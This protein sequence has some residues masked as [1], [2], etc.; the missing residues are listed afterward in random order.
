MSSAMGIKISGLTRPSL[1]ECQR[2]KHL[3]PDQ[4]AAFEVDL[5]FVIR[6][7]FARRDALANSDLQLVAEPQFVFHRGLEP[8]IAV[9]AL[10]LGLVHRDIGALHQRSR[11]SHQRVE[12]V[13]VVVGRDADRNRRVDAG[14]AV[15]ERFEHDIVQA[16][17]QIVDPFARGRIEAGDEGEFVAAE[18]CQ[19]CILGQRVADPV[20]ELHQHRI[21]QRMPVQIVDLFE[22]VE[23][24]HAIGD[25]QAAIVGDLLQPVARL[26]HAA[27]V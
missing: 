23:V 22:I 1:G 2:A 15:V 11:I 4:F 3:E 10:F 6:D 19:Q 12:A 14:I 5:L 21:A 8:E 13:F 27:A 9:L 20:G 26:V 18:P 25:R 24:E 17:D 7:E 16:R